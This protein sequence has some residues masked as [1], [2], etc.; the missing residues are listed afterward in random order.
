MKLEFTT[1]EALELGNL[2]HVDWSKIPLEKFQTALN[3]HI[4]NLQKNPNATLAD[5]QPIAVAQSA[6]AKLTPAS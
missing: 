1:D 5:T 2:I 3:Q 6:L 4:T